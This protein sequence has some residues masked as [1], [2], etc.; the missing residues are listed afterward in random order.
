MAVAVSQLSSLSRDTYN[1]RAGSVIASS[2]KSVVQLRSKLD[3]S[4]ASLVSVN[5]VS[6]H[7]TSA[8]VLLLLV[9]IFQVEVSEGSPPNHAFPHP[10]F[11][12]G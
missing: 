5:F 10:F 4:R 9:L 6:I 3:L 2:Q 8:H 7:L 12:S 11:V 1:Y